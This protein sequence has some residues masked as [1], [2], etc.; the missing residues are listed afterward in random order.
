MNLVSP[1]VLFQRIKYSSLN[2]KSN[3][4]LQPTRSI[5]LKRERVSEAHARVIAQSDNTATFEE[6]SLR[7]R[8]VGN[9]VQFERSDI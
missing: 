4:S 7:W 5:T 9:T 1:T 6:M 3:L 2:F 8:A